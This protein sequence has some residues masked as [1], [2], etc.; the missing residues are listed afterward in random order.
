MAR[1]T[2][3]ALL[4]LRYLHGYWEGTEGKRQ[5]KGVL[6]S[7]DHPGLVECLE[8]GWVAQSED[9]PDMYR[10]TEPGAQELLYAGE[11]IDDE[12]NGA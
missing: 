2:A 7:H 5:Y 1:A 6:L 4:L 3:K 11:E 8:A 10:I 12:H 9:V